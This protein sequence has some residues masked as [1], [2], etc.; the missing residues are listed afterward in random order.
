MLVGLSFWDLRS[1]L[2]V[3]SN[4]SALRL[5]NTNELEE[6]LEPLVASLFSIEDDDE[7]E[8]KRVER[9]K[10]RGEKGLRER[11]KGEDFEERRRRRRRFLCK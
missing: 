11:G 1:R 2:S 5:L 7:E 10:D 9:E 8:E 4:P 3:M 6:D